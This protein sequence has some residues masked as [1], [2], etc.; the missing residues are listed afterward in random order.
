MIRVLKVDAISSISVR[1]I[2]LRLP[3]EEAAPGNRALI[4]EPVGNPEIEAL[5][6]Q[7]E[8]LQARILQL[9]SETDVLRQKAKE[10]FGEGHLQG[11]E[12]GRRDVADEQSKHSET[13]EKGITRAVDEFS[14]ALS[15]L[16]YLAPTLA[17]QALEV[18][19]G[20]KAARRDMVSAIVL[21]QLK[22]LE[23]QAVLYVE[24][25]ETDFPGDT[26]RLILEAGGPRERPNGL[27]SREVQIRAS[28]LLKSGD[29]RIKLKLGTLEAGLE[30]Q[31]GRLKDLLE[32]MV[33]AGR[34]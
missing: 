25:S 9:E 15:H 21:K 30:D 26:A 24:V 28:A 12:I 13:L 6:V 19:I 7:N 23:A 32:D 3:S 27:H 4:E 29:C 33:V 8:R 2:E 34:V 16:E 1:P 20:D 14:Q 10:A 17:R 31:W 22:S 5:R 18:I 11:V